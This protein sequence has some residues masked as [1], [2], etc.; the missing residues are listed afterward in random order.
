M[1]CPQHGI[2]FTRPKGPTDDNMPLLPVAQIAP[3][4]LPILQEVLVYPGPAFRTNIGPNIIADNNN[5]SIAN[6]FCFGAFADKNSGILYQDLTGSFP[7][8]S[9]NGSV[10]FFVLYHYKSNAILATPLGDWTT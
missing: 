4:V 7:F 1:K 2:C 9:Y 3:P 8:M 6:V 5:E 10:C